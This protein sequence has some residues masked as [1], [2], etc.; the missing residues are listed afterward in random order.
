MAHPPPDKGQK[1]TRYEKFLKRWERKYTVGLA[2]EKILEFLGRRKSVL[3]GTLVVAVFAL[4]LYHLEIWTDY[5]RTLSGYMLV[6]ENY[7]HDQA[8]LSDDTIYASEPVILQWEGKICHRLFRRPYFHGQVQ[9]AG[10][11]SPI[12]FGYQWDTSF[13]LPYRWEECY[14]TMTLLENDAG[15]YLNDVYT[16]PGEEYQFCF[17]DLSERKSPERDRYLAAYY[18]FPATTEEEAIDLLLDRFKP[19]WVAYWETFT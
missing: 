12:D 10:Y 15:E 6:A 1:D 8:T 13:R 18:L 16:L 7:P 3:L 4:G 5:D 9:M 17:F 14:S 19:I 2:M 11:H